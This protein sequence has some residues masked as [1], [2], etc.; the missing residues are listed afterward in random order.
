MRDVDDRLAGA[1][2]LLEDITHLSEISRLKSEFIA[3]A[4]H[5]LRT[6]L[7]SAQMG[8]HL[9]LEGV[10][11]RPDD[12]QS[13]IL[14]VCRDDIARLERLMR[15]LLDLRIESGAATA[16]CEAT[17]PRTILEEAANSLRAP[18]E[19]SGVNCASP[20]RMI[21]RRFSSIAIRSCARS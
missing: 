6:P 17:S 9:L 10:A 20:L 3:V 12:R 5:E 4:S 1:V 19:K 21:C 7:T 11:G 18:I 16:N 15:E 2:T 8:I 14:E 13:Q